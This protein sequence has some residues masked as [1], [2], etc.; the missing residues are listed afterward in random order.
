VYRFIVGLLP[1][2]GPSETLIAPGPLFGEQTNRKKAAAIVKSVIETT[3]LMDREKKS[4]DF[5]LSQLQKANTL[6]QSAITAGLRP[7]TR[8]EGVEQQILAIEQGIAKIR[9][10]LANN[11]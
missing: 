7:E 10:W 9:K 2:Q 5:L 3:K 11:A 1:P 8:R 6:I 4:T